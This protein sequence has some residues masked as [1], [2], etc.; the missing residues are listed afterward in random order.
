M[1]LTLGEAAKQTGFSK[2]T[3]SRAIKDGKLTAARSAETQSFKIDPSELFRWAEAMQVVRNRAET[4]SEKQGAT[5]SDNN[6]QRS[7]ETDFE[8]RLQEVRDRAE[9]EGRAKLAEE[10]LADLKQQLEE[11]KRQRDKWQDQAERLALAPPAP[12]AARPQ[13]QSRGWWSWRRSAS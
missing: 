11:L 2:A 7:D 6:R 10:R 3:L 5:S 9:L 12:V 8:T 13:P 1:F 4:G